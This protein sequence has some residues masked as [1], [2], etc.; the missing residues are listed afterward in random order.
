MDSLC[1]LMR[2]NLPDL[3][4]NAETALQITHFFNVQC[5]VLV[6]DWIQ[7]H[8]TERGCYIMVTV[9]GVLFTYE[10]FEC[11]TDTI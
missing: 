1:Y 4:C 6:L 10:L 3:Q 7:L 8:C 5:T 11:R 2:L 9:T